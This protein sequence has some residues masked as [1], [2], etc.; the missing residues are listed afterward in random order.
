M[1]RIFSSRYFGGNGCA[2]KR[3]QPPRTGG[4]SLEAPPR[5]VR[6]GNRDGI[7]IVILCSK[8]IA[9]RYFGGNGCAHKRKQPPR[10]G[11]CSLEAPPRF[12]LGN[13]GFA[14]PCLTTWLWRRKKNSAENFWSGRRD[15][16]PRHSP[17]QGDALPLSHSRI[18]IFHTAFGGSYRARTC[19]PLLVGQ[20]LSQLS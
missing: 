8:S 1:T 3:K 12:E 20:L 18:Y 4:C 14:D 11:G 15:S 5:F 2:H 7:A 16:N 13:E 19:D 6:S 9:S 17:W 10:T